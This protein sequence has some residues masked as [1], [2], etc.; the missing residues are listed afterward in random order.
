MIA[1]K[2][3]NHIVVKNKTDRQTNKT[4]NIINVVI[5]KC[6]LKCN[7]NTAMQ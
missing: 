4:Y 5:H 2:I 7:N 1:W 3:N 6:V